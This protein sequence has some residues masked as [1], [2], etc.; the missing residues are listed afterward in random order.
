[1]GAISREKLTSAAVAGAVTHARVAIRKGKKGVG[2][3][4]GD[5][6]IGW[7]LELPERSLN[8]VAAKSGAS[9]VVYLAIA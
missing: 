4:R 3:M 2:G 7:E 8:R 9:L 5:G 6:G 1:M